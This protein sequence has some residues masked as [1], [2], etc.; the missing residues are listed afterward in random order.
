MCSDEETDLGPLDKLNYTLLGFVIPFIVLVV[1][2][3]VLEF[4][5]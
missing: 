3:A 4:Q 1:I 2:G 5:M